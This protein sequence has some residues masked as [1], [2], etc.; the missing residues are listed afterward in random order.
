MLPDSKVPGSLAYLL[1]VFRPV[2]VT[3]APGRIRTVPRCVASNS[4]RL[5]DQAGGHS[6]AVGP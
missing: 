1:A 2:S 5:D 4:K 6:T 3:V